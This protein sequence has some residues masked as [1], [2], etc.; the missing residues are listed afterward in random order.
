MNN[1]ILACKKFEF[2]CAHRLIGHEGKCKNLHGHNY[3]LEVC[4]KS[5]VGT[6]DQLG[7][8]IDFSDVNKKISH[9][10]N[11]KLDHNTIVYIKDEKLR[12]MLGFL[13]QDKKPYVLESNTTCENLATHLMDEVFQGFFESENLLIQQITLYE[14]KSNKVTV[15][16]GGDG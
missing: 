12:E 5:K 11:E 16:V 10:L 6:L 15:R 3:T 13:D 7:R 14:S 8:V 9:W 2:C 4:L 1:T